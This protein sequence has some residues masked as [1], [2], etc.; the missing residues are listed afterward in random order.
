MSNLRNSCIK[1]DEKALHEIFHE[2]TALSKENIGVFSHY[3]SSA[4]ESGDVNMKAFLIMKQLIF[5]TMAMGILM[6]SNW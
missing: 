4:I 1:H 3:I 5:Q 2:N 6:K